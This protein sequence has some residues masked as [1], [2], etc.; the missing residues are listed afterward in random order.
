MADHYALK[1]F[2]CIREE[3]NRT[4]GLRLLSYFIKPRPQF[5]NAV[6]NNNT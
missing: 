3:S 5:F 1:K 6:R 2:Y 4:Q